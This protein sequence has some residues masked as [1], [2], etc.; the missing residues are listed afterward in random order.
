MAGAGYSLLS[1]LPLLTKPQVLPY[2]KERVW[3]VVVL[4]EGAPEPAVGHFKY[5]WAL[6]HEPFR[7][8]AE[9]RGVIA[10][11]LTAAKLE[12][13]MKRYRGEPWRPLRVSPGD[14]G[15]E[16]AGNVSVYL[17]AE[18]NDVLLGL[19]VFAE[20][21]ARALHLRKLYS[22][23]PADLKLFGSQQGPA[24]PPACATPS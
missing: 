21:G 18:R 2:S 19:R 6:D 3:S 20:D 5:H 7:K 1:L 16:V 14:K 23:L 24:A 4:D 9:A 17:M 22:A 10:D 11:Q 15:E 8:W 13:L 12:R